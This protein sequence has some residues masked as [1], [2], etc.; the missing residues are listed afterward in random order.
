[1]LNAQQL[2]VAY[3]S[4]VLDKAHHQRLIEN[5]EKMC[6]LAGIPPFALL[7]PLSAS[8]TEQEIDL[9][10]KIKHLMHQGVPGICYHGEFDSPVES[11]FVALVAMCMRNYMDA[12]LMTVHTIKEM[13]NEGTMPRPRILAIPNFYLKKGDGGELAPWDAGALQGM[14]LDR[15]NR[16]LFTVL[17]VQGLKAMSKEWGGSLV[18]HISNHYIVYEE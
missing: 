18:N 3:E 2:E 9:L 5:A 6:L 16:G 15:F 8:C 12:R 7:R 10:K 13:I 14:L 11:K 17:Y 4:E 1:M